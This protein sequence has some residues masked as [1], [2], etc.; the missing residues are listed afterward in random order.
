MNMKKNMVKIKDNA[1]KAVVIGSILLLAVTILSSNQKTSNFSSTARARTS[2]QMWGQPAKGMYPEL[3]NPIYVS[4]EDA[5][6]FMR[7]SD[8]VIAI[9][10]GDGYKVFPNY[11]L[12][13]HHSLNDI[14]NGSSIN[15]AYCC[16][17]DSAY[18]YGR[19]ID[20]KIYD[21]AAL[22]PM[23]FGNKV[24]YDLQ[25][26]SYWKQ[27]TGE[28]FDGK[29]KGKKLKVIQPLFRST[30]GHFR[31]LDNLQVLAPAKEQSFYRDWFRAMRVEGG[32]LYALR[33]QKEEDKRLAPYTRGLG[34]KG[35]NSYSFYTLGILDE[36]IVINDTIGKIPVLITFDK[37]LY[38]YRVFQ[39]EVQGKVLTLKN[40]NGFLRDNETKSLWNSDGISVEGAMKGNILSR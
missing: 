40:E 27:L 36:N 31:D 14:I 33:Q 25:T 3:N 38:S 21:F 19:E 26:G 4:E 28:A 6:V 17:S 11:I 15:I 13:Y 9:K 7:D 12:A 30:W 32:G 1:L 10:D 24:F 23:Y 8:E 39:R 18:A 20:G 35:Q 2:T 5:E 37:N 16:Q 22:G 29:L 34:V